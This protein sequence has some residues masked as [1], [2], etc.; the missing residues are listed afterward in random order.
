MRSGR[1]LIRA[2]GDY[3][4][5]LQLRTRL[6]QPFQRQVI[7]LAAGRANSELRWGE[8]VWVLGSLRSRLWRLVKTRTQEIR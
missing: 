4:L 5:R 7:E 1:P 6:T 8:L 2:N 3:H